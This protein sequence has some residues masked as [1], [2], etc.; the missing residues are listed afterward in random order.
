MKL[1]IR[2]FLFV[3]LLAVITVILAIALTANMYLEHR[4]NEGLISKQLNQVAKMVRN[5]ALVDDKKKQNSLIQFLSNLHTSPTY[6]SV[7]RNHDGQIILENIPKDKQDVFHQYPLPVK[8]KLNKREW[9]SYTLKDVDH[10]LIIRVIQLLPT[11]VWL[12]VHLARQSTSVILISYPILLLLIWVIT[13]LSLRSIKVITDNVKNR[14]SGFLIPVNVDNAPKEIQPLIIE[15][16]SLFGRL[17]ETVAREKRFASDAAHELRTP[18]AAL[19]T[20]VQ[21]MQKSNSIEQCQEGMEK[22]ILGIR[23]STHVVQQLLD[24]SRMAPNSVISVEN[25]NLYTETQEVL[26]DM[27][28][29]AVKKNIELELVGQNRQSVIQGNS[30]SITILVRNLVDN[31]IRYTPEK[32][33]ILVRIQCTDKQTI[34][35]IEDNG[36]GIPAN[37][38]ERVFDRF[39]RISNHEA[40]GCGLGLGIVRQIVQL[41]RA[42]IRLDQSK[43]STG[44]LV[45]VNFLNRLS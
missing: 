36:P 34:L 32:G 24:I 20:H 35:T 26:A 13:G 9:I 25:V 27:A 41:H 22:I 39:Y 16:N 23:R 7:Q 42:D 6:F 8:L 29:L 30:T 45:T 40:H 44:L 3:N 38:R 19:H 4:Y 33:K 18:L 21:I 37:K 12:E 17:S 43:S 14:G 2:M 5:I 10:G 11:S 31:A 15:L 28:P 1:S